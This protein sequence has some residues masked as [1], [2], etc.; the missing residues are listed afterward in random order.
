[1][2]KI[3]NYK[4]IF[5]SDGQTDSMKFKVIGDYIVNEKT[6]IRLSHEDLRMQIAYK[7]KDIW[8]KN[9]DSMLHLNV[10]M[11]IENDYKVAYGRFILVTKVIMFEADESHLK[12]KYEL[13][14][15]DTLVS[16]VYILMSMSDIDEQ[17][18]V[19]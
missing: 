14:Q 13:Y 1:M 10:D 18:L 6:M 15:A 7:D 9:N 16:T 4:S 11:M 12:L 17:I 3:I 5:V 19:S 2:K 8:L